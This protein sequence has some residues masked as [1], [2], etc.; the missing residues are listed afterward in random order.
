MS[1]EK[2]RLNILGRIRFNAPVTLTFA[3]LSLGALLLG[4]AT[5]GRSTELLFSTYRAKLLDPL[6]YLR[7]FGHVLGHAN[8]SHYIGNMTLILIL[9]PIL[10]EKYG[11]ANF[12]EMICITAGITGI[13][14]NIFFPK[15]ILLGASGI[16]FMCI[17]LASAVSFKGGE[18]PITLILVFV[19]YVGG[20]I[21]DAVSKK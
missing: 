21:M 7:L 2:K 1:G 17:I 18:I 13:I 8:W 11:S 5:H 20:E 19:I 16:V 14:H 9:G 6:M 10:E 4:N 12:L 15:V 3:L